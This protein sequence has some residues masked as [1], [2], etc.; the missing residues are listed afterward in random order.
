MDSLGLRAKMKA[1]MIQM[2]KRRYAPQQIILKAE[3]TR[4]QVAQLSLA[5]AGKDASVVV[6]VVG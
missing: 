4:A 6:A 1:G 2:R 3:S 5:S